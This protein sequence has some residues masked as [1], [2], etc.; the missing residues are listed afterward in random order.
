MTG[1]QIAAFEKRSLAA[2]APQRSAN[3]N[4]NAYAPSGH[5]SSIAN[6]L[7]RCRY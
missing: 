1:S 2:N 3:T 4:G 6:L 7:G 5:A